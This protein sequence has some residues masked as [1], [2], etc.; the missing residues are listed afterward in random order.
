MLYNAD[1]YKG[2]YDKAAALNQ[3]LY[4]DQLPPMMNG[5]L[6]SLPYMISTFPRPITLDEQI[7]QF[8]AFAGATNGYLR[9]FR[10]FILS[11]PRLAP[12]ASD[13]AVQHKKDFDDL[14]VFFRDIG[15][16]Y[17]KLLVAKSA[18]YTE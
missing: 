11:L 15:D 10:E 2:I 6:A 17:E 13:Y 3:R 18:Q 4:H 5:Y 14:L 8:Q 16:A 1:F 7:S 12:E 9:E